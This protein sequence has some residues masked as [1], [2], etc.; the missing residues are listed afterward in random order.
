MF[1]QRC[2]IEYNGKKMLLEFCLSYRLQADT[3]VRVAAG[4]RYI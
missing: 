4:E 3:T 2:R 1:A